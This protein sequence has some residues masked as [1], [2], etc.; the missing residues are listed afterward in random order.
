MTPG[1]LVPGILMHLTHYGNYCRSG[2]ADLLSAPIA[3]VAQARPFAAEL[4][5]HPVASFQKILS[6]G[7]REA[8]S[9]EAEARQEGIAKRTLKRA[10]KELR[11]ISRKRGMEDVWEW[12]YLKEANDDRSQPLLLLAIFGILAISA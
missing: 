11:V 4:R 1:T 8:T 5:Q 10:K 9:V 3:T 7:P 2:S 12:G 6:D